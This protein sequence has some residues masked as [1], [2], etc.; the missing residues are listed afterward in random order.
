MNIEELKIRQLTNQ[1][2]LDPSDKL[3]VIRDLCGVQA[4]F[5]PNAMHSLRVRCHDFDENTVADG[6]VK[7]WSVRGTVHVFAESDLPLFIRCNNGEAYRKNK[8]GGYTFW[9]DG[10][11]VWSLTPERQKYFSDIIISAVS[12]RAHTRDELKELCRAHG[13]DAEEVDSMFESWGGGI[14]EL[15]ERGFMHY[16][17]QEKKAYI[18]SPEFRPIPEEEAK[19][20]IA[21]RY[22]TNIGP[23]TIHDAM[24]YTGAKQAEVKNWL[25]MLPVESFDCEGKTYYYIPNGK[26]YDK[27]IPPCIFLAGFDQ[28]MLGYQ[29]KESVYLPQEHLRGI[30]NLAGIVMPPILLHGKVVGKWKKKN[31]N[32]IC[33]L[34]ETV[35]DREKKD[36]CDTAKGLWRS[37]K[38]ITF[39]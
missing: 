19:L 8:W 22:F 20:E 9:N 30:F 16:V 17:V 11:R 38:K 21:R 35:S 3:T 6:L 18:A 39:E 29:K 23:A 33:T 13:M 28:L 37:I 4:Q 1:H 36:I 27:E 34:F 10:R 26:T 24:Y 2:L 5:F 7:N 12:E 25:K 15:C 31:E 32:L 14:R